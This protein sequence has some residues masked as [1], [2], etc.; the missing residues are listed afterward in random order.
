MTAERRPA[1]VFHPSVFIREEMEARGWNIQLLSIAMSEEDDAM[2]IA[3][4]RMT[5]DLYFDLDPKITNARLGK[6]TASKLARA[7]DVSPDYFLNL[8]A[9]WLKGVGE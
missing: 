8:E 6:E 7:F 4:N 3:I 5:L 2:E 1:E 9:A